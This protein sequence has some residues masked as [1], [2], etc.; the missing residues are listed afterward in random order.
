M[1]YGVIEQM[2]QDWPVPPM[3][4]LLE[5]SVSGYYAW[6]TRAPSRRAQKQ[7]RLET[8]ILAA[9]ERTRETFGPERLQRDL[10][11]HGVDIG[12]HSI[13]RVRRGL[14]HRYHLLANRRRLAI[15]GWPEGPVQRRAG[16]LRHGG[17]HDQ[18]SGHAGAHAGCGDAPSAGRVVAPFGSWGSRWIQPV[19][20]TLDC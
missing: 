6:R 10:A 12:V 11:G 20:A 3:C 4:R 7:P 8:E 18:E 16:R 19:V 9:H 13:K 17:A 5:V 1:K 14:G 15:S 2:R